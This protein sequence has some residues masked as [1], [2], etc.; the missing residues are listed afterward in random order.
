MDQTITVYQDNVEDMVS[1]WNGGSC[2]RDGGTSSPSIKYND[3]RDHQGSYCGLG[4]GHK[5]YRRNNVTPNQTMYLDT[6]NKTSE[7]IGEPCPLASNVYFSGDKFN[8]MDCEYSDISP[9]SL[10]RLAT[11]ND[12]HKTG[13]SMIPGQVWTQLAHA[14]CKADPS[15]AS[16]VVN[17]V[18]G[19]KTCEKV[20]TDVDLSQEYCSTGDNILS[21]P[22]KC[23]RSTLPGA[24]YDTIATT[25][26]TANKSNA[27]CSCYNNLNGV[28]TDDPTAGGCAGTA[29]VLN[30]LPEKS[31]ALFGDTQRYC[32]TP[33][34]RNGTGFIP[35]SAK[36]ITCNMNVA[37]C[38]A[39]ASAQ[40]F[41]QSQLNIKQ[42][43]DVSDSTNDNSD[44]TNDN[45]DTTNNNGGSSTPSPSSSP[46][47]SP[48][49]FLGE[50][51][52]SIVLGGGGIISL[53]FSM[54]MLVLL[55]K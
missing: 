17:T 38:S 45:S 13:G 8:S 4:S 52:E 19:N 11:T 37:I 39:P 46:S 21:D 36:D 9:T 14:Y 30:A 42:N 41:V 16:E 12:T 24:L 48:E 35:T 29:A 5:K 51:T 40:G 18:D 20:V 15:R 49:D 28:C 7:S 2:T 22:I 27:W 34:C 10:I 3:S 26:C 54:V 47:S 23:S 32:V 55:I 43:C 1:N 6:Q 25:W 50:H 53:S 44:T 31:R 33:A